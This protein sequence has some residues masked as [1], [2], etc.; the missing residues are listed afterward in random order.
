MDSLPYEIVNLIMDFSCPKC[1]CCK[2]HVKIIEDCF[3]HIT[4]CN[5]RP[6]NVD[7]YLLDESIIVQEVYKGFQSDIDERINC[8]RWERIFRD[9]EVNYD[10]IKA[11]IWIDERNYCES[12]MTKLM[13]NIQLEITSY[14][15][16][17][18][19]LIGL[20]ISDMDCTIDYTFQSKDDEY[21]LN[22]F[23]NELKLISD[24]FIT[25]QFGVYQDTISPKESK[26]MLIT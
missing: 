10:I 8:T 18:P 14:W 12:C 24:M 19:E 17:N 15:E 7:E 26:E 3:F 11:F 4:L 13:K 5:D 23:K 20:T 21:C 1:S 25:V 9:E 22:F 16:S 6:G 2:Q